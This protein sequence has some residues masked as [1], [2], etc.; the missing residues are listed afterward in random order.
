MW[1]KIPQAMSNE[2]LKLPQSRICGKPQR[3]LPCRAGVRYHYAMY[4]PLFLN[5]SAARCLVV[6]AGDVGLRKTR[7]LLAANPAEVLVLDKAAPGAEWLPLREHPTLRMETRSFVPEDVQGRT[8]VFACT[9][10][11]AVNA[12]V[13]EAC[14]RHGVLCNCADAP[15]EGNCIVPA[16]ARQGDLTAA[17]STG[18]GSP[19]WARVLRQELEAWL[20][21]R[22]AM[23][24]LLA[25]LRPHVLALGDDTGQNTALFRA[26]AHSPLP[27]AL[28]EKDGDRCQA[29]LKRALPDVLHPIIPELLHD[30]L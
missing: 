19:A 25:R 7:T 3:A 18:G 2:H 11:R 22:A 13:A 6:G 12:A 5:L 10:A 14:S 24:H 29:L 30:L 23:T 27:E 9:S 16:T 1:C 28:A 20:A 17:L 8:L 4:Y 15:L 26:L 21:P